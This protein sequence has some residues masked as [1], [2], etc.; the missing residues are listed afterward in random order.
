MNLLRK[1]FTVP[2]LYFHSPVKLRLLEVRTETPQ[3]S[4]CKG[5]F[6]ETGGFKIENGGVFSQRPLF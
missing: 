3:N 6:F 5:I 2:A 1:Q 4:T